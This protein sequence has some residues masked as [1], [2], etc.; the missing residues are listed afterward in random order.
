M[1]YGGHM[2]RGFF[3]EPAQFAV[4]RGSGVHPESCGVFPDRFPALG[5]GRGRFACASG[6]S[7]SRSCFLMA[8]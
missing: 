8:V 4:R 3:H 1:S 5:G 7:R 2:L 6:A